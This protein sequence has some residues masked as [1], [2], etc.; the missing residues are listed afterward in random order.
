[1]A[2]HHYHGHRRTSQNI[3]LGMM[4]SQRYTQNAAGAKKYVK[5][6]HGH[7]AK[8]LG[9]GMKTALATSSKLQDMWELPPKKSTTPSHAG[10][11]TCEIHE[12]RHF[13]KCKPPGPHLKHSVCTSHHMG[14]ELM[15]GEHSSAPALTLKRGPFAMHPGIQIPLTVT[16]HEC[17]CGVS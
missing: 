14:T 15:S 13:V 8:S 11:G 6:P 5:T 10:K 9:P 3:P 4:F 16:K 2:Q 1:M 17:K 7:A 12:S